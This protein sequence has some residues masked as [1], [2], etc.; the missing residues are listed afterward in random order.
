MAS[1]EVVLGHYN[2]I[3]I[4]HVGI[5][6]EVPSQMW[7]SVVCGYASKVLL[8]VATSDIFS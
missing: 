2:N 3:E 8:M 1:S 6:D 4:L 7:T 5:H